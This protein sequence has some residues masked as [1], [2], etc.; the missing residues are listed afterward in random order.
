MRSTAFSS[1]P[2]TRPGRSYWKP[3][4][5]PGWHDLFALTK[6]GAASIDGDL[7][8]LLQNLQY[9][10]DLLALPRRLRT[11]DWRPRSSRWSAATC[12]SRST[13]SPHRLYFEEA[14]PE[15]A[16]SRWSACTRPAPTT[17]STAICWPIPRSRGASACW[18]STCRG[19]ASRR[20]PTAGSASE[21]RLTTAV[22]H[23]SDPRLLPG[24]GARQ[25]G[26]HGL[27]DRRAHRAQPR[28]RAR[29]RVPRPDRARGRRLPA[30]LVRHGLAAPA[31]RA[32][33]RGLRRAGLGPDRAAQPAGRTAT[34]RCGCTCR[35]APACS[36]ATS[37]S[38]ASTATCAR[39]SRRSTPR[40]ARSTC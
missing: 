17:A 3:V 35:A 26:G 21:Y 32:W 1:A 10:K 24:A 12:G 31:G 29:R 36:K 15:G 34:R 37:I 2:P 28:D 7:R 22:L 40:S 33:R 38:I 14:G 6:R 4:P 16:A 19:T 27:L 8:P 39:R 30:A 9:F 18:P 23:R 5:E 25:A 13:A 20:R 11:A